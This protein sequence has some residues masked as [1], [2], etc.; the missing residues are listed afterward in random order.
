[1]ADQF[2]TE[3][4]A[5][6]DFDDTDLV[7][8][9]HSPGG[10]PET[11]KMTVADFVNTYL[12]RRFYQISRTVASNN[13]TVAVKDAAGSNPTSA[14]PMY[15]NIAGNRRKLSGSLSVTVNSV[16][17]TFNL[18]ATE[19]AGLDQDLFVYVGWRASDSSVFILISRIPYGRTYADFSTTATAETY[20]AYSGAA[21]ASTDPVTVIGR[22]NAQNS[23]AASYNWSIPASDVIVHYPIWHTRTLSYL[24]TWTSATPPA[25]GNGTLVGQYKIRHRECLARV[26][27]T[28]GSTTTF[29]TGTYTWSLP[30]TSAT[31][32]NAAFPGVGRV[33]DNSTTTTY[34][35][36]VNVASAANTM[37]MTTHSA[38]T[39]V[40]AT[41]PVTLATSDHV[42]LQAEFA[43]A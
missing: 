41:V 13:L 40:S 12:V 1:M 37:N 34:V 43:L 9:E 24:P 8:I 29:G 32:T 17:N 30:F 26:R 14:K 6:T 15:F 16:V 20:G 19:F 10:T 27:V 39:A 3:L 2:I 11:N 35:G 42:T 33:F 7:V 36:Q 21:P 28:A 38:T 4:D 5:I 22:V 18:G 31:F 23:G 25:L